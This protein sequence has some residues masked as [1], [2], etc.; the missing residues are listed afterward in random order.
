MNIPKGYE[1]YILKTLKAFSNEDVYKNKTPHKLQ[2]K[3][4]LMSLDVK[5]RD[6]KYRLLFYIEKETGICKITNLCTTETH[7]E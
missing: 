6:D 2:G 3:D 1:T 4:N 5:S 7:K